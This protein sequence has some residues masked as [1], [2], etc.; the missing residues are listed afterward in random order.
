MSDSSSTIDDNDSKLVLLIVDEIT[1]DGGLLFLHHL[2]LYN[3]MIRRLLG[4]RK[5]GQFILAHS[6]IFEFTT[7]PDYLL[8]QLGKP[9]KQQKE[10]VVGSRACI[11]CANGW[12][13]LLEAKRT[14]FKTD[15]ATNSATL[16]KTDDVPVC[17]TT[18]VGVSGKNKTTL[19]CKYCGSPFSSR[20]ALF[21]HIRIGDRGGDGDGLSCMEQAA[22]DGMVQGDNRSQELLDKRS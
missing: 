20:N 13:E 11:R 7:P 8:Q 12:P 1:K 6:D 9:P 16:P 22:N 10:G 4:D 14:E 18:P 17:T 3:P 15:S 19:S 5:L 21:K 2:P